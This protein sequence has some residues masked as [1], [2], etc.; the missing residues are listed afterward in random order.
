MG[1][2]PY[3]TGQTLSLADLLWAPQIY[4]VSTMPEGHELLGAH[5]A[6]GAWLDR[7]RERP[8]MNR[9]MLFGI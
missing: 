2:G 5:P 4:Y 3:L 8:A 6:I 1:G 7:M 9:T